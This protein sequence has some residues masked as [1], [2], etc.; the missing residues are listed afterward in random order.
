MIGLFHNSRYIE[1]RMS[2]L[3]LYNPRPRVGQDCS[4]WKK[5]TV[6]N[7]SMTLK[8]ILRRFIKRESLP[9]VKEG[10]YHESDY[11]LEKLARADFT[12]QHE[13]LEEIKV[14]VAKKRKKMEDENRPPATPAPTPDP[15]PPVPPS[16]TPPPAG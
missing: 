9:I 14:D 15:K 5:M 11:D 8:E 10:T 2:K 6:P 1:Y 3:V 7:Q 4:K 13:V 12:E 16:S